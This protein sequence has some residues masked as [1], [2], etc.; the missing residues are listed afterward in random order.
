M[1]VAAHRLFAGILVAAT[2]IHGAATA[3]EPLPALELVGATARLAPGAS[4]LLLV[5]RRDDAAGKAFS[6]LAPEGASL[7]LADAD[8]TCGRS[9]G[10]TA[11][12]NLPADSANP[13]LVCFSMKTLANGVRVMATL[14]SG[15]TVYSATQP[16][17]IGEPPSDSIWDKPGVSVILSALVGFLFG[18][19]SSWFQAWFDTWKESRNARTDAQKFIADSLFPELREHA[20]ALAKYLSAD[21][22]ELQRLCVTNLKVPQITAALSGDRLVGLTS[23][24]ASVSRRALKTE[25]DAYDKG[26]TAFNRWADRLGTAAAGARDPGEQ[27]LVAEKL[28]R[29]LKNW[30]IA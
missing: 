1:R 6:L 30:K 27:K 25:L 22:A 26:L 23:Y 12:L 8:G 7:W 20:T 19:G 28:Y 24:F 3:V 9:S 17:D 11:T 14:T 16:F 5:V 29:S 10:Q 15:N 18:L 4:S 2:A 13:A 21:P